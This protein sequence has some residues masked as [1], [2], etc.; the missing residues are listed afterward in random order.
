VMDNNLFSTVS[1]IGV[2]FD[3]FAF[4]QLYFSNIFGTS[5]AFF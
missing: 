4:Y 2:C 5:V 1:K 3:S